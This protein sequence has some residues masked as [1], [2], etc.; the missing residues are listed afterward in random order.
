M[1]W[2]SSGLAWAD[3]LSAPNTVTAYIDHVPD[4]DDGAADRLQPRIAAAIVDVFVYVVVLNLFVEYLP[5]VISETFTLSLLTA[6][7]LKGV[8]EVVVAAK[9][10]VKGRFRAASTPI[11]KAVA[12]VMLWLVLFGSKFLVLEAVHLVFGHRVRL[13]GFLARTRGSLALLLS[14]AAVRR[15]L[16][17]PSL[18]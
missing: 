14:R 8:L 18:V 13:G 3:A 12:G 1:S 7:L 4:Q 6:V 2:G 10:R 9:N 15:L 5:Q 17:R 11:G 16:R